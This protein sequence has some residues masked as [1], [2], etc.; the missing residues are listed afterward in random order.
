MERETKLHISTT[1]IW[2][3]EVSTQKSTWCIAWAQEMLVAFPYGD[4]RRCRFPRWRGLSLIASSNGTHGFHMQ[5]LTE[6]AY[7]GMGRSEL[8]QPGQKSLFWPP[9][10]RMFLVRRASGSA[11]RLLWFRRDSASLGAASSSKL[12]MWP[13]AFFV[14][15]LRQSLPYGLLEGLAVK[16]RVCCDAL[17]IV[18]GGVKA[19]EVTVLGNSEDTGLSLQSWWMAW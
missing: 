14:P 16:R 11:N 3:S 9:G 17:H 13:Q 4:T 8:H 10:C 15:L 1:Q 12:K 19:C 18:K 7:C 2:T 6:D 5:Q